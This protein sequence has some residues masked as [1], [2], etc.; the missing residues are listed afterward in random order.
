MNE[1]YRRQS[2]LEHLA[3]LEEELEQLRGELEKSAVLSRLHM[4]AAERSLQ[5]LI[6]PCIGVCKQALKARGVIAP[7]DAREAFVKLASL[8]PGDSALDWRR[9]IGLRNVLVH[10][11]LN[12]VAEVVADVY[13]QG[14]Y[15]EL[16]AFARGL[17]SA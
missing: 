11:Y 13:R 17:L 8:E 2:M 3:T 6:E 4:R 7:S 5:L 14:R 9:I 15:R 1:L 16:L 10:D 12:I